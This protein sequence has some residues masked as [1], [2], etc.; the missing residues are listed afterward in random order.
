MDIFDLLLL[1]D[2]NDLRTEV[3]RARTQQDLTHWDLRKVK[4]V[5]E[6]NLELKLQLGVLIRLLIA[7]GVFTAQEYAE[8][9]AEARSTKAPSRQPKKEE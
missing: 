4:D 2:V 6:E 8:R 5:A 9:F 3:E 1:K 7:K